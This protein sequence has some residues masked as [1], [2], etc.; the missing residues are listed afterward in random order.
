M[1]TKAKSSCN[2]EENRLKVCAGCGKKIVFGS[3]PK[4]KFVISAAMENRIK[5]FSNDRF[6]LQDPRF[7]K[8]IC[9]SCKLAIN[10]RS[11]GNTS[12]FLPEMPNFLEIQLL[13]ETRSRDTQKCFCYICRTAKQKAHPVH[14]SGKGVK[15]ESISITTAN[16]LFGAKKYL[17]ANK[18]NEA[19][20]SESNEPTF[21]NCNICLEESKSDRA[22]VCN[23]AKARQNVLENIVN[24]P[25]KTQDNILH[26]LL[27]R[28]AKTSNPSK[29]L[30]NVE[31][32]L[33][34]A[35]RS[36]TVVLN[37][38]RK[39]VYFSEEKVDNFIGN[40][41]NILRIPNF[42]TQV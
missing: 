28:K 13:K 41:G 2:H 22:H 9:I 29:K 11:Q 3:N 36:A 15:K 27:A 17:E 4:S 42:L 34:T 6:D 18:T 33:Q 21:K 32:S 1:E 31:M 25:P 7:P 24:L 38:V 20:S 19:L 35:G 16:G 8:S 10:K 23:Q 26:E 40:T 37:P 14:S 5:E 30:R 12:R 39:R